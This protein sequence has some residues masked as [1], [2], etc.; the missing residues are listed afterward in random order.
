MKNGTGKKEEWS[1][2]RQMSL[3]SVENSMWYTQEK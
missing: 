1:I 3:I 2:G